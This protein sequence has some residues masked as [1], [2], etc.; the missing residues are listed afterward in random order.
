[1]SSESLEF[2][3]QRAIE[4]ERNAERAVFDQETMKLLASQWRVWPPI[5][6]STDI[7]LRKAKERIARLGSG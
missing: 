7:V 4:C 5:N 2:C 1:M 6:T 3:L